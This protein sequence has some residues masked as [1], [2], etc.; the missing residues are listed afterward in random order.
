MG[1][2]VEMGVE[3]ASREHRRRRRGKVWRWSGQ[4]AGGR[5]QEGWDEPIAGAL[6]DWQWQ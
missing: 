2:G 6:C 5:A 4:G 1:V 3:E